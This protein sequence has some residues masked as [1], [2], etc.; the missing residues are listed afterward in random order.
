MIKGTNLIYGM[1]P[2][3]YIYFGDPSEVRGRAELYIV[4]AISATLLFPEKRL[5]LAWYAL[6]G[7]CRSS[8][9]SWLYLAWL[10]L[11]SACRASIGLCSELHIC[12]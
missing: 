7:A 6:L 12:A 5:Y 9:G 2:G 10:T 1:S 11:L 4:T 8:L 3:F